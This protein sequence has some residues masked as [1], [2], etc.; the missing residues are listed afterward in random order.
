MLAVMTGCYDYEADNLKIEPDMT[1]L[2]FSVSQLTGNQTRMSDAVVQKDANDY[3]GLKLMAMIPF[4]VS[5]NTVPP[6]GSSDTPLPDFSLANLVRKKVDDDSKGFYL[7]EVSSLPINANSFLVYGKAPENKLSGG[8]YSETERGVLVETG[9]DNPVEAGDISFA[10]QPYLS[11]NDA[12]AEATALAAYLTHIANTTGWSTTT[13]SQLKAQYLNF[14]GQANEGNRIL[15]GSST[16]IMAHVN[17]L[18]TDIYSLAFT[19]GTDEATIKSAIL[20]NIK[21]YTGITFDNNDKKVTSLGTLT[22]GEGDDQVTLNLD[23]YPASLGLPDGAAALRWTTGNGFVASTVTTTLD[24]INNISRFCY[25]AELYYFANSRIKISTTL[26]ES[27]FSNSNSSW[28]DILLAEYG[29]GVGEIDA[30]VKSVAVVE[31]LQYAV[32]KLDVLFKAGS[33]SLKD[34][35]DKTTPVGS[36]TFQ[37]TGIIVADQHPVGFDFRPKGVESHSD[38]H[39]VYDKEGFNS[40][41]LS[42]TS[43]SAPST[44]VLQTYPDE[45]VT[46]ILEFQNNGTTFQGKDGIVYRD[47]KFY[48]I[49]KVKPEIPEGEDDRDEYEKCVFTQD[50]TTTISLVVNSLSKAYNVLPDILG[51]RLEVGVQVVTKWKQTTSDPVVLN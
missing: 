2:A 17:A 30:G 50:Y 3:R 24:N 5:N 1:N 48:L 39:F 47:T 46:V 44:L 27:A 12:P 33:S 18:Y 32:A 16:N 19:D 35:V 14:T 36:E 21:N 8:T 13:D 23:T 31:P 51:E 10:P 43:Q 4:N 38:D 49:G 29:Q 37:L 40:L 26:H 28:S 42:T 15:A 34:A 25:P 22:Q 41:Y 9:L 20:N 6:I 45:E 7:Y 11:S